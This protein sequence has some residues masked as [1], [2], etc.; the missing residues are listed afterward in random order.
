MNNLATLFIK[1][2]TIK[3]L[4]ETLQ[5]KGTKGVE[6]TISTS[7]KNNAYDQNVSAWVAQTKEEREAEKKKFYVGNGRVFWGDGVIPKNEPK[8]EVNDTIFVG[9]ELPF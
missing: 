3:I 9:D 1:T 5:K 4:L 6:L 7:D 2:E 8:E